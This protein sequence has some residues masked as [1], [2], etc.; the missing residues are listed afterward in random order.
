MP[1]DYQPG[2]IYT[3]ASVI[4][5]KKKALIYNHGFEKNS[6]SQKTYKR[7]FFAGFFMKIDGSL[8]LLK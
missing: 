2:Y 7:E 8:S 3:Y 4:K 6:K 5:K 1:I